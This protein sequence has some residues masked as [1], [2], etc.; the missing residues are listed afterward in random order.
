M[1]TWPPGR[2]PELRATATIRAA[3]DRLELRSEPPLTLRATPHA[4][5]TVGSAAGPVGGDELHL[6]VDVEREA[7]LVVRSAAATMHH[8]GPTGRPSTMTVDA[9]VRAACHLGWQPEPAIL[10]T[11]CDHRIA[12]RIHLA[13][14]ATL[15]WREELVLG[16]HGEPGGSVAARVVVDRGGRPLIRNEVRLGPSWPDSCGPAGV[17]DARAVGSLLIVGPVAAD[18]STHDHGARWAALR[19]ADDVVLVSAIADRSSAI[20]SLFDHLLASSSRA[21]SLSDLPCPSVQPV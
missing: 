19:L 11:G 9:N 14:T 16:R 7:S 2:Q 20:T 13:T 6:A 18:T 10:V 1:V 17:E 12:T 5:Y 8:P 15:V 3:G 21:A 4:V